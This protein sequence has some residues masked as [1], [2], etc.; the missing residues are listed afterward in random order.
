MKLLTRSSTLPDMDHRARLTNAL[1]AIKKLQG[2]LE[3]AGRSR[4]EPIALIGMSCRF[5]G[6]AEDPETFW[7]QL[8]EG[9]DAIREVPRERWDP[10]A[11]YD[12]DPEARGKI[13]TRY[14][15]FVD[16][17]RDFDPG[18]FGISPREAAAM[19]PQQRLVLEVGWEALERAGV[20]PDR[21]GGSRTGVFVGV[22]LDDFSQLHLRAG[23]VEAL[24]VYSGTGAGLCFTAGRLSFVLGLQGP[25]LTVDTACSSSLVALHL[26]CQSLRAG[27]CRM[28]LAGGVNVILSPEVNVYLS[29]ARA[30]SPDG[31][32]KTFDAAA[33]GYVRGEGCGMLV[34]KR[35]SDA[36]ADGDTILAV[37][38]G[39]AV[40]HDGASSGLT[41]PNGPAQQGVIRAAL[42]NAGLEPSRVGYVEAH[43]TGTSLGD[44]IE[45]E[46]L[47]G[48]L[49]AGRSQERPLLVGAVKTNIG[50][51]E[52]AA[53]MA[54]VI[55]AAQAVRYGE[56]PP[57]LHLHTP[58]P[59]IPWSELPV[60]VPTALT[61]WPAGDGPRVAG[62]SS[63]GLSGT[64]AHVL[65]EEAP[66][67]EPLPVEATPRPQHL[68]TLSARDEGALRRM[69]ERYARDVAAHPE[70]SIAD[71]CFTAN[72]G[73]ARFVHRAAIVVASHEEL[74]EKLEAVA[75]GEERAGVV[76]GQVARGK[77][78]RVGFLFT[79]QGSQYVGM[80]RELY[81]TAPVFREALDRCEEILRPLLPR[82]LL[83]V[84]FGREPGD[85]ELLSRTQY[86][87]PALFALEYAL[88]E[89]WRSWGVEPQVVLGHSV[90]EVAAACVA[91]VFSLEDGLKLIAERGRLMQSLPAGGAM[92]AVFAPEEKVRE[93]LAG[94]EAKVSV[95]AFNGPGET[96]ISGSG[97]GVEAVLAKLSAEGVRAKRLV[98]SH[99]FH[100]PL[101]EPV[102]EAFG[103][104]AEGV[105]YAEPK[106]KL[107]ANVTGK[108]AE[109]GEV[110]RGEY[111]RRH[112]REPVRFAQ[113]V[114]ALVEAGVDVV[115]EVG[116]KATLLGMSKQCVAEGGP[117]WMA[118]LREG[119]GEWKQM[120]SALGA[121]WVRGAEVDWAALESGAARRRVQLPTYPWQ[122]QTHWVKPPRVS[123][124]SSR[125]SGAHP[126]L[127]RR[128]RS[129][130][131]KEQ[132]FESEISVDS[133]PFLDDHRIYGTVVVPGASHVAMML[134]AAAQVLGP[135]P[136]SI[137][138]VTFPRALRLEEGETRAL[139]LVW[140][141]E[142]SGAGCRV[143]SREAGNAE[144][145]TWLLHATGTARR[146]TRVAEAPPVGTPELK[147][148]SP[149]G[150][151]Q[152]VL[153]RG[154]AL[155]PGFQW[156]KRI[157]CRE[158]EAWG[159]LHCP[160]SITDARHYP[161]HPTLID[162]CIQLF[163]ATWLV[164]GFDST[165]YVPLGLEAFHFHAP[166]SPVL[167]ARAVLRPGSSP[168]K[169]RFTGDVVV[170]DEGGRV[171]AELVGLSA[172]RAPRDALMPSSREQWLYALEWQRATLPAPAPE[173]ELGGWLIVGEPRGLGTW[174][175]E[176]LQARGQRVVLAPPDGEVLE[177][178]RSGTASWG[179][180]SLEAL[181]MPPPE[182][183]SA[184]ALDV[185]EARLCGGT[186]RLVQALARSAV[187]S[188]VW[189][190]TRGAQPVEGSGVAVAQAPLWGMGMAL[191]AE[192][193]EWRASLVDLDPAG[194]EEESARA[195]ADVLLAGGS[196]DRV[197]LRGPERF[198][199]RLVARPE[200]A[201][202][203]AEPAPVRLQVASRGTLEGLRL[204]PMT[205]RPPGPGEVEV[206]V[207]ATG[208]NFRDVLNALGMYPGDAG[209]LGLE[210]SGE[211][212]AVGEGVQGLAPGDAVIAMPPGCFA[213]HATSRADFVARRPSWMSDAEAAT[214]PIAFLTADFALARIARM[215]AGD[216]VLIHAAAGG[217]GLAA[218]QLAQKAGAEIFATAGNPEKRRFLESLGVRHV[219]D[220]R[221]LGFADEVR[222]RTGG[223][224]VDIVLNSLAGD[225]IPRSIEV[226][227]PGGRFVEIGKTGIWSP[228]QVARLRGDVSYAVFALDALAASE[229]ARVAEA[230]RELM[231]RVESGELKPLPHRV[232][233][234]E[235][236][237]DAFRYMAQ[238]RHIGKVVL[239]QA[240]EAVVRAEASYLV[241]GGLG[242]LGLAVAR[243]LVEEGARHLVLMGRSAPSEEARAVLGELEAAGARVRVVSGDVA[244]AGSLARVLAD[245]DRSLP[246]LRGVFHLAGV[247]D[248]GMLVQ[249]GWERFQR[250]LAPKVRGSWNLH[251]ATCER[252]LDFF[253]LFSSGASMLGSAGQGNYAA[254]NAFLDALAHFR[255]A[256]G[257]PAL[258]INWGPWAEG[259]MAS[260]VTLDRWVARG[261]GLIPPSEGM[262]LLG[263]LMRQTSPQ[264]GVLPV[265]WDTFVQGAVP[266]VLSGL[267]SRSSRTVEVPAAVSSG[268]SLL[269]TLAEAVPSRR[270]GVAVAQLQEQVRRVLQL[271]GPVDPKQPLRELGL[272]SLMA[273][274]LRNALGKAV[275]RTLPVTL[276]FDHPTLDALAELL[277]GMVPAEAP[278]APAAPAE[279]TPSSL[280]G[281]TEA[282]VEA[283]LLEELERLKY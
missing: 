102:L 191:A 220:S 33:D 222:A 146:V 180:V 20:A 173:A 138:D 17:L 221:S 279:A 88:A 223:R 177:P 261:M 30:I 121:L 51:L 139:Q 99:A 152:N 61:P 118:S 195:L 246:P 217:V 263:A 117:E 142:G 278:E 41:V 24:D 69:A 251:L 143:Y 238:A 281:L 6:G 62:V 13:L 87:Q 275:G 48:V 266:P 167:K 132:L 256:R 234:L 265:H 4:R 114:K 200:S 280:D 252:P 198:V 71:V 123:R 40:N 235:Q 42:E 174:L 52:T 23:D 255:R 184:E 131:L 67:S 3:A 44:P 171:V 79:G 199:A 208:L 248:D 239:T 207:R 150:F 124:S 245:I 225:F 133:L 157:Q 126:L 96:V 19:D 249:Q 94:Q 162:A 110:T 57:N 192:H 216:R 105:G 151:Y 31:R 25:S 26:A 38:R 84:M 179:V 194:S 12:P 188:R 56:V 270:R 59:L 120:L 219:M 63:F 37:I 134:C 262:R 76:R 106:L 224:G 18:F 116:P 109:A 9:L 49:G 202:P 213:T 205:R 264:L 8:R 241:T 29:R 66:P 35:L 147:D 10:D 45:V 100:S 39:S 254:G 113:G 273:V 259:G 242:G 274:E 153:E 90:G 250:V 233:P 11:W 89:L 209:P 5:P 186:L 247:L 80:G 161:L 92:A 129:P 197:A 54:G 119:Q 60:K 163:G 55:K 185:A 283:L 182:S 97:E 267:V 190:V 187:R 193:P 127:G 240:A 189:W 2:E 58:N 214:L 210:C 32:C 258:S 135:G 269:E 93:A 21:L 271:G 144:E 125:V 36:Q 201:R 64:N 128:V 148:I 156:L 77:K 166:P 65:V 108:V 227:A 137:E 196:E 50:H 215:K 243:W 232:F 15:G 229:P 72:T 74:R 226:L 244:D 104:V 212:V 16:G 22:G 211:V 268:P 149:E 181:E 28:A 160:S 130:A 83:S 47:A 154:I 169:E 230:F 78:P 95:A 112:V 172:K 14:G 27:D 81:E 159:E 141:P 155:G 107:V 253:V 91:G 140:S 53:G 257:L 101:M 86:T 236:A 1:L 175:A 43:G 178:L 70:R 237:P 168:S 111:W 136:C 34:L 46:A 165:A 7:R 203:V 98:V 73:R 145:P 164:D 272:D 206:R 204:E 115:V 122:R 276:L 170:L 277:L 82:P 228:E 68:L 176:A 218:V 75:G 85:G 282:Q 260:R 231:P 183:L 158:G 103:R